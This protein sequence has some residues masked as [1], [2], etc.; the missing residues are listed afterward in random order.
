MQGSNNLKFQ[1]L[2]ESN[3]WCGII[4]YNA[5][6]PD[7]KNRVIFQR[8]ISLGSEFSVI[9]LTEPQCTY[10]EEIKKK[11]IIKR[12][13]LDFSAIPF[14]GKLLNRILF[15][16]WA[17]YYI[18][19]KTSNKKTFIYT[20]ALPPNEMIG[21]LASVFQG[22]PWII[23]TMMHLQ[24]YLDFGRIQ[25]NY[26]LVLYGLLCRTILKM[27]IKRAKLILVTSHT[28]GDGGARI[29]KNDFGVPESK[30]FPIQ[31]GVSIPIIESYEN[32]NARLNTDKNYFNIVHV[33][34]ISKAK[35]NDLLYSIDKLERA[36]PNLRVLLIGPVSKSFHNEFNQILKRSPEILKYLGRLSHEETLNYICK[37]D[38][39][40][41]ML[42]PKIRDYNYGQPVKILEY[43]ALGKPVVATNL[44]GIR[45]IITHG[46]N[47]LLYEPG[48]VDSFVSAVLEVASNHLLRKN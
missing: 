44:E 15:K 8:L 13:P 11:L 42:N 43:L 16:I 41:C 40:V 38:L 5:S 39:C 45:G 28:L 24:Y 22:K 25:K 46:Y 32:I 27:T 23:E 29:L 2:F 48:N 35:G 47:G 4:L 10:P 3:E 7:E 19:F 6:I 17:L 14:I 31:Q 36:M 1:K 37:S 21:F 30:I 18:F 9:L 12:L 20:F 34:G 26:L 33:G